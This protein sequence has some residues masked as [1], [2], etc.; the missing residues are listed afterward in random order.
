MWRENGLGELYTYLPQPNNPGFSGNKQLCNVP[1][2]SFCNPV[3]GASVGR[4]S[5]T[6]T[7]GKWTVLSERVKLNDIGQQNGEL[8]VTVDGKTMFSLKGL[9]FRDSAK[10][11]FDGYIFQAFFGGGFFFHCFF[12]VGIILADLY[13]SHRP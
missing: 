12:S 11:R 7:P 1:P 5:W 10:G 3:T 13:A 6:F 9:A 2:Y 8:E 4:G